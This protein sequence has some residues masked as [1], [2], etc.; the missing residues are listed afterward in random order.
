MGELLAAMDGKARSIRPASFARDQRER[1]MRELL[2]QR[3]NEA[4]GSG[5]SRELT[6]DK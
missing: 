4:C 6:S 1:R 2:Q 3:R 5:F